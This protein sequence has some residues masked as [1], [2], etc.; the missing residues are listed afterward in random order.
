MFWYNIGIHTV[1]LDVYRD[2]CRLPGSYPRTIHTPTR[3]VLLLSSSR[4]KDSRIQTS[5]TW[6]MYDLLPIKWNNLQP[7]PDYSGSTHKAVHR[8]LAHG[9]H[10]RFGC[11]TGWEVL[12]MYDDERWYKLQNITIKEQCCT[13][14]VELLMVSFWPYRVAWEFSW[15]VIT[16]YIQSSADTKV[17]C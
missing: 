15:E 13:K 11:N 12:E 6:E 3:E 14:D 8:D 5:R 4:R 9:P 16:V 2:M 17:A 1:L 7:Q 10:A